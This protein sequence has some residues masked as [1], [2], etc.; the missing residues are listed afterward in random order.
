MASVTLP[1]DL[2]ARLAEEA[3]REGLSLQV[4][5]ASLLAERARGEQASVPA[6]EQPVEGYDSAAD[7]LARFAGIFAS[8]EPG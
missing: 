4:L 1:E 7:P 8:D 5:I 3:K 2:Y 6:A